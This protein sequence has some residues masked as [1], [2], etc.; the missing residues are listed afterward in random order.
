M[1]EREELLRAA[2]EAHA[3]GELAP[4]ETLLDPAVVWHGIE[5]GEHGAE[6]PT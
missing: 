4:W 6:T 3:Q 1:T 2:Y 5:S